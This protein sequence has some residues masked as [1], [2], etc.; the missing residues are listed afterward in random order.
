[1]YQYQQAEKLPYSA[2]DI[3]EDHIFRVGFE[4]EKKNQF[5]HFLQKELNAARTE[6]EKEAVLSI[7][8]KTKLQIRALERELQEVHDSSQ[9]FKSIPQYFH[10]CFRI[11]RLQ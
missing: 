11:R 5:L 8:L 7:L 2:Q 10:P 9:T 1:M 4:L 3:L 6:T